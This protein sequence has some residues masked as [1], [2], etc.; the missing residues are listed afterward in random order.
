[1]VAAY[2]V[3]VLPKEK[4]EYWRQRRD[5][6]KVCDESTWM[7]FSEFNR[8]LAGHG[9]EV[10]ENIDDLSVLPKLPKQAYAKG[11][12]LFCRICKCFVPAK[13]MVKEE[14]CPLGRWKSKQ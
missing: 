9:V 2:S 8:W 12:K 13:A 4:Y 14:E 3:G 5:E 11:R 10:I 7:T 1:M 6:C